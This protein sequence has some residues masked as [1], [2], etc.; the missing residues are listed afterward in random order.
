MTSPSPALLEPR[1][2]LLLASPRYPPL[3]PVSIAFAPR[4]RADL[5]L[6]NGA[7]RDAAA[8]FAPRCVRGGAGHPPASGAGRLG[9]PAAAADEGP[10]GGRCGAGAV[11]GDRGHHRGGPA[12]ALAPSEGH[13][14]R[15]ARGRA[16]CKCASPQPCRR[17]ESRLA[18]AAQDYAEAAKLRDAIKELEQ[19]SVSASLRAS[20]WAVEVDPRFRLGQR[21]WHARKGYRGVVVG[22]DRRCCEG[23]EWAAQQ[24]EEGG[25]KAGANQFFYH[26][27]VDDR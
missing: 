21:V 24:E 19:Q 12:T 2:S 7:G 16:A 5:A 25:L 11:A 22:W 13:R 18:A 27:L 9:V 8:R 15:G 3:P 4:R 26:V 6:S 20:E 10:G 23:E 14:R 1:G 17:L